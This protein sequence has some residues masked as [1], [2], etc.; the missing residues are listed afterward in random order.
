MLQEPEGWPGNR[1]GLMGRRT[2]SLA[3]LSQLEALV[4]KLR[5]S[6]LRPKA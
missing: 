6:D 2:N 4:L 1:G 3:E 5:I